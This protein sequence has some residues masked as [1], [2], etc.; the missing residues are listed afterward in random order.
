VKERT[1]EDQAADFLGLDLLGRKP[2]PPKDY[3]AAVSVQVARLDRLEEK[4]LKQATAMG[5]TAKAIKGLR[6]SIKA[7]QRNARKAR[8]AGAR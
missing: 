8:K 7:L 2:R 1:V 6:R 4:L 5:V 3:R